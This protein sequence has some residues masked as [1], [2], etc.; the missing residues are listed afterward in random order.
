MIT[1][2]PEVSD[3]VVTGFDGGHRHVAEAVGHSHERRKN[4][5]STAQ[6]FRYLIAFTNIGLLNL[7]GNV[8]NLTCHCT[9][10]TG[11]RNTGTAVA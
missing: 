3:H 6:R 10:V 11:F 1:E 5:T 2:I 8:A 9:R 7:S 4:Q